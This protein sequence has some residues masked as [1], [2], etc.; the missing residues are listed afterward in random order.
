VKGIR[1]V[2]G[3]EMQVVNISCGGAL[4]QTRRRLAPGTKI[5][6]ELVIVEGVIR[7]PGFVLRSPIS[8]ARRIPRYQAAIVFESPLRILDSYP[9]SLNS[10]SFAA[11]PTDSAE[12]ALS[13]AFSAFSICNAHDAALHEISNE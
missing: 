7:L 4:L 11:F 9:G 12:S 10:G 5:Q 2:A 8:S 13:A 6:L 1:S 3:A